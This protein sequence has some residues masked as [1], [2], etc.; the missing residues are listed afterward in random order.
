[1]ICAIFYDDSKRFINIIIKHWKAE[2]KE[3]ARDA[4]NEIKSI[5]FGAESTVAGRKTYVSDAFVWAKVFADLEMDEQ[6]EP[7]YSKLEP[8]Q[9]DAMRI[10]DGT[11][12][13]HRQERQH[14]QRLKQLLSA[15]VDAVIA[16]SNTPNKKSFD[17]EE[18]ASIDA[19]LAEGGTIEEIWNAAKDD[20]GTWDEYAKR[21]LYAY[22][23]GESIGRGMGY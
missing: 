1:M 2:I 23:R 6:W 7:D 17:S 15:A 21:V 12:E 3:F 11:W 14:R 5:L 10:A 4:M 19:Y 20:L 22:S 13:S 8:L 9:E 18:E 16:V